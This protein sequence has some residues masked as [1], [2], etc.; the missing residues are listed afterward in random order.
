MSLFVYLDEHRANKLK[1]EFSLIPSAG[2]KLSPTQN[3]LSS[4]RFVTVSQRDAAHL[5]RNLG[6]LCLAHNCPP[7]GPICPD[8]VKIGQELISPSRH[9][10]CPSMTIGPTMC[11]SAMPSNRSWRPSADRTF[12]TCSSNMSQAVL[13][14]DQRWPEARIQSERGVRPNSGP[15]SCYELILVSEVA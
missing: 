10:I 11:P 1:I 7:P 14:L 3:I 5:R 15:H 13:S 9:R 12:P 2:I 6:V 8:L 4:S